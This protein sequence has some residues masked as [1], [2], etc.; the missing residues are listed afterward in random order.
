[1][2]DQPKDAMAAAHPATAF[3]DLDEYF[4]IPRVTGMVRSNDGRRLVCTVQTLTKERTKYVTSLWEVDPEGRRPPQR[5]TRSAEGESAPAFAPNGDIYFVS[6][7][8]SA[9]GDDEAAALWLLPHGGGEAQ[10]VVGT[11]G[12]VAAVHV[13]RDSG[14][15]FVTANVLP[16]AYDDDA[17]RRKARKDAGVSALLHETAPVRH[18]DH[19][20]GPDQLRLFVVEDDAEDGHRLRDLTP[21]PGRGLDEAGIAVSA[22]GATVAIGWW[23]STGSGRTGRSLVVVDTRTGERRTV[24]A[25]AFPGPGESGPLHTYDEPAISPDGRFVVV[26]DERE[27]DPQTAPTVTLSIADLTTGERRDLLPGF[28]L[29]PAQPVFAPDGARVFFVADEAGRSPVFAVD[30]ASGGV[31]RLTDDGAYHGILPS[32]DGSQLCALRATIDEP[33]T[34]VRLDT[35][36][37]DQ[38]GVPLLAPGAVAGVPGTVTEVEATAPD[39]VRVRAWLVLPEAVSGVGGAPAPAPLAVWVH[40]GPLMSW[41]AWSW[42]WNPWLLAARGWAV[43]LPDPGLSRGYGDAFVQ[44]AWGRW[45]EV[46]FA[47]IIAVVDETLARPDVDAERVALMGGSYGGY[48]ANWV[49][50]HT[51]RFKAIVTHASLWD[52]DQFLGTTDHA[53]DWQVEWGVPGPENERYRRNSPHRHVDAITTPMLVVHGDKD[54]RVPVS[55][56]LRLWTDLVTRDREALFLYFPDEG[57]WILKPGNAKVWYQTVF[58]FLDHHV[59]GRPWERPELL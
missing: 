49:A 50:G 35:D 4:A 16:G 3:G 21:D 39:G 42:R 18:W 20:L 38:K 47:D 27:G 2:A 28:P 29:W 41:T 12:G 31:T 17:R 43:L 30:V 22:D 53:A 36:A 32:P 57:H 10:R 54:Y 7:R 6:K 24:L 8:P 15:V 37:V 26:V 13:A 56:G 11:S 19:D 52:L 9:D 33:L 58:A 48:M 23:H 59:L 1:M 14:T 44:R 5:L 45:G 40:G 46:P 34:P 55:E 51:D 25:S